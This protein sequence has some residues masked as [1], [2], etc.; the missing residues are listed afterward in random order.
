[1]VGFGCAFGGG[2]ALGVKEVAVGAKLEDEVEDVEEEE[3]DGGAAGEGEDGAVY[4]VRAGLFHDGVELR[5]GGKRH[6]SWH[7]S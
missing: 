7:N 5:G 6:V 3:N 2:L 4:L 1:M